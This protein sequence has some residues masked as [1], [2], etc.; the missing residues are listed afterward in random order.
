M[1]KKPL[2][3][4]FNFLK[5]SLKMKKFASI[6]FRIRDQ[7]TNVQSRDINNYRIT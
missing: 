5:V 2:V 1:Q 6:S 4:C 7:W 3:S